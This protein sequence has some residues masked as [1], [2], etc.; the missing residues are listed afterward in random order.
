L[1]P[2]YERQRLSVLPL[3]PPTCIQGTRESGSSVNEAL[4][5]DTAASASEMDTRSTSSSAAL[6]WGVAGAESEST[7]PHE[8]SQEMEVRGTASNAWQNFDAMRCRPCVR[9]EMEMERV[10]TDNQAKGPAY[11]LR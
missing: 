4:R 10:M 2:T 8:V 9:N 11:R 1:A 7:R 6:A 5:S 3:F